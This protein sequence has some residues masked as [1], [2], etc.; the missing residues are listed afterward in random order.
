M[1]ARG[2]RDLPSRARR[3]GASQYLWNAAYLWQ[4]ADPPPS[5]ADGIRTFWFDVTK[6]DWRS[7]MVMGVHETA[8]KRRVGLYW[9]DLQQQIGLPAS[10]WRWSAWRRSGAGGALLVVLVV[11]YCTAF[12]F[13]YTYNV[14]DVHVFFLPSHQI[15]VLTAAARRRARCRSA[16]SAA[17]AGRAG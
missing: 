4:V 13:A 3:S 2:A 6:S 11:A 15:V 17:G 12:G 8:L 9:F 5:L 7:T 16:G 1:S 10:P 14:G